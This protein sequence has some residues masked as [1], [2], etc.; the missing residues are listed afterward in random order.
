MNPWKFLILW[1]EYR[2]IEN[3]RAEFTKNELKARAKEKEEEKFNA[4]YGAFQV[5]DMIKFTSGNIKPG[6]TRSEY[7]SNDS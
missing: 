2:Q 5:V 7:I 1:L 6:I 4:T 3:A